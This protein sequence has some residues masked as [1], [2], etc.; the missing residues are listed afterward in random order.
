MDIIDTHLHLFLTEQGLTYPWAVA[1]G[2][3]KK[4]RLSDYQTEAKNT[5]ITKMIHMEVD[6]P[7]DQILAETRTIHQMTQTPNNHL[8]GQI[9]ACR[10]E[11]PQDEFYNSLAVLKN[12]YRSVKGVR[13]ILHE[14]PDS[15]SRS[16]QFIGNIQMLSDFN[17]SFDLVVLARQLRTVAIPLI[18]QCPEVRFILD[19]GGNPLI[20]SPQSGNFEDWRDNIRIIA[21]LPNVNCKISGLVSNAPLNWRC[22]DL[23][24]YFDHLVQAFGFDRLVWGSDWPVCTLN[25]GLTKW[26]EA[27]RKLASPYSAADQ[28][29]LFSTNAANI[30]KV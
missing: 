3:T 2:L 7:E 24:P 19:H 20:D 18:Y 26:V 27:S 21:E 13:R 5:G 25:G 9:A 30:Y 17:F 22:E 15:L 29:K 23:Q 4:Y 28:Q 8:L 14:S 11:L 12:S 16:H 6:V 1:A 10:P